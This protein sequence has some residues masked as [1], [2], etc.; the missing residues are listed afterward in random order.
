MPLPT[1]VPI[2][3]RDQVLVLGAD[4]KHPATEQSGSSEKPSIAGLVASVD[5]KA[6]TFVASCTL[7][8]PREEIIANAGGLV[9]VRCY[10]AV[11][12]SLSSV[13]SEL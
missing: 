1:V 6:T 13:P 4:V 9:K 8:A 10:S 7:Q 5:K 3:T 2:L 12:L 11:D